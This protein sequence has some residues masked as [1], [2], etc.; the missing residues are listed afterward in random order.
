MKVLAAQPTDWDAAEAIN[1]TTSMLTKPWGRGARIC[2]TR[3]HPGTLPLKGYVPRAWWSLL[4]TVR[5]SVLL[6]PS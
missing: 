6:M 5:V 4:D 1:A 3:R 2:M